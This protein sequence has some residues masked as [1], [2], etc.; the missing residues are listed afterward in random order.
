MGAALDIPF[1]RCMASTRPVCR[2][3]EGR[4]WKL[5]SPRRV[6]LVAER[7]VLFVRRVCLDCGTSPLSRQLVDVISRIG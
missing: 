2:W 6:V 1:D 4:G 5:V 3:C 7:S